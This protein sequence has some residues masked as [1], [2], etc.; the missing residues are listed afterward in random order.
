MGW[1]AGSFM[2]GYGLHALP[3]SPAGPT[4]Q[5]DVVPC[6]IVPGPGRRRNADIAETEGPP[7]ARPAPAIGAV[8]A[9]RT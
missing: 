2:T 6:D 3:Q 9:P 5:Y 7:P 1:L 8:A 4:I